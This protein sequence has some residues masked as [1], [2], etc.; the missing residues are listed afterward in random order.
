LIIERNVLTACKGIRSYDYQWLGG[1]NNKP[2]TG[3]P[4]SVRLNTWGGTKVIN[5]ATLYPP[6]TTTYALV[7]LEFG[8]GD[9]AKR[10]LVP[11]DQRSLPPAPSTTSTTPANVPTTLK[12][13]P[14]TTKP[15]P[16]TTTPPGG[17]YGCR[18]RMKDGVLTILQDQCKKRVESLVADVGIGMVT[19]STISTVTMYRVQAISF[20][21]NSY[22]FFRE[23][24]WVRPTLT[25]DDGF[26][27]R[28]PQLVQIPMRGDNTY[29][30]W[31]SKP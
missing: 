14:T 31:A 9:S 2:I 8:D 13:V 6:A 15:V 19:G 25:L 28:L 21:F 12:P 20:D 11:I 24:T 29:T 1:P 18:A 10:V 17:G 23:A 22:K 16:T 27:A 5:F 4:T 30:F 26:V 7:D 3:A